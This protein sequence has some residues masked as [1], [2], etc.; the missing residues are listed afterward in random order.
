MAKNELMYLSIQIFTPNNMSS[1]HIILTENT[2]KRVPVR[3]VKN[4][5]I[6]KS[7]SRYN[8]Y[9]GA[10]GDAVYL[11]GHHHEGRREPVV[12]EHHP[13]GAGVGQIVPDRGGGSHV[14]TQYTC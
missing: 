2:R 10:R 11:A 8:Y 9:A 7:A 6:L 4:S 13:L 5:I 3:L 14:S 12:V 1:K